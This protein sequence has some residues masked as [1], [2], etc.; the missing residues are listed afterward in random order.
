MF[1]NAF[2][3]HVL[4]FASEDDTN[5]LG[6]IQTIVLV[7]E[8]TLLVH[9][10]PIAG[11][12]P[13][14]PHFETHFPLYHL[15]YKRCATRMVDWCRPSGPAPKVQEAVKVKAARGPADSNGIAPTS[16]SDPAK[17]PQGQ[18]AQA[19]AGQSEL[20]QLVGRRARADAPAR[21]SMYKS[22]AQEVRRAAAAVP[23]A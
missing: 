18:G 3:F 16:R 9:R 20:S 2:A 6:R 13:K 5:L 23:R 14:T 12:E 1:Q 10:C 17:A 8:M 19:S 22:E 15:S 7:G 4:W 21:Q 11:L